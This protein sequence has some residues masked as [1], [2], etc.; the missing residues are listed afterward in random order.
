MS[1][2]KIKK[3]IGGTMTTIANELTHIL[4]GKSLS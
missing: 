1:L 2:K 3:K 4:K